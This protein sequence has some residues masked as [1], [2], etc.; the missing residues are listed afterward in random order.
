MT[1][2]PTTPT[3]R[4][5]LP[6]L[7]LRMRSLPIDPQR[8]IPIPWFVPLVDGKPEFRLADARKWQVAVKDKRCW[9][10]GGRLGSYLTFVLGPMCAITRTTSEPPCH[11]MCAEYSAMVC[12]FLTKPR[13]VRRGGNLPDEA[14]DP[15]GMPILRNPG[16]TLLWTTRGYTVFESGT[17][18]LIKVGDPVELAWFAEGRDATPAEIR[19]SIDTGLPILMKVAEEDGPEAI[20]A[21]KEQVAALM[22]MLPKE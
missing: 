16:V 13:M 1:L 14:V 21:L 10:C 2:V 5:D 15:A 7:P 11:F 19:H 3:L 20:A 12:P 4:A 18:P 8:Q 22:A 9:I 17:G 6:P